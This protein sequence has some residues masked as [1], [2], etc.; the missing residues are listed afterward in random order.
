VS[1][2]AKGVEHE[3]KH[4]WNYWTGG[5]YIGLGPGAHTRIWPKERHGFREAR[6]QTLEP[7]HIIII[8]GGKKV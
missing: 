5:D 3:S 8:K 6:I 7:G 4:N 2:F 1:N